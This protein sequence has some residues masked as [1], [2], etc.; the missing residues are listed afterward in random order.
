MNR[1]LRWLVQWLGLAAV[2]A[3]L[4]GCGGTITTGI[5]ASNVTSIALRETHDEMA[6][7]Y[8]ATQER[9]AKAADT[10]AAKLAAINAVSEAWGQPWAAYEGT[11]GLWVALVAT[12]QVAIERDEAGLP[13]DASAIVDLLSRLQASQ[14]ELAVIL[15]RFGITPEGA[16]PRGVA[17]KGEPR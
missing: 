10:T 14:A 1:A 2:A 13:F 7:R 3:A 5:R 15:D 17:S 4:L 11:R 6:K 8:E 16:P 12:L 9:V